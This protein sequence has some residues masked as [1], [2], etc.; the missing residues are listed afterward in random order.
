MNVQEG[1]T[2]NMEPSTVE[3]SILKRD[4]SAWNPQRVIEQMINGKNGLRIKNDDWDGLT[5]I[6]KRDRQL[7]HFLLRY[8]KISMIYVII[9][10]I[11]H[12]FVTHTVS[13]L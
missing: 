7:Q 11:F 4:G 1:L 13:G 3:T 10:C 6:M 12:L 8:E 9:V 2:D 5:R